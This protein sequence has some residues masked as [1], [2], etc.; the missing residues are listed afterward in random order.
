VARAGRGN[1]INRRRPMSNGLPYIA[2]R[3]L[4]YA[5]RF[6]LSMQSDGKHPEV[7]DATAAEY[8]GVNRELVANY[9]AM[10]PPWLKGKGEALEEEATG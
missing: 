6:S 9:T 4:Y 8:Y 10:A 1:T 5:V 7:A 2:N 3:R